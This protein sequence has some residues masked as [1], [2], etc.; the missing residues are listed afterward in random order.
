MKKYFACIT[1]LLFSGLAFAQQ[2]K[3]IREKV[4]MKE[5]VIEPVPASAGNYELPPVVMPASAMTNINATK[6]NGDAV[7]LSK[8]EE[9]LQLDLSQLK[10]LS[11]TT[12]LSGKVLDHKLLQQI[13]EQATELE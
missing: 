8:P 6:K 13:I 7:R 1:C 11:I 4:P 9:L 3:P 10:T 2:K 5:P 12:R